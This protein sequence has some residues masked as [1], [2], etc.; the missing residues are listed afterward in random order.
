MSDS[1][2]F[3]L[4]NIRV[5]ALIVQRDSLLI[6]EEKHGHLFLTKFPGGGLQFGE[7][8][9]DALKRELIE[10]LNVEVSDTKLFHVTESFVTSFLNKNQ[11][12]VG[13]YY[14]VNLKE[15][16]TNQYLE[17]NKLELENGFVE[18]KWKSFDELHPEKFSSMIDQEVFKKLMDA[19]K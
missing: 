5:Y 9:P 10:E 15:E 3:P 14:L 17:D 2:L 16:L 13:V 18:F 12:V 6:T 7:S 1:N 4:F 11:Q 19:I 8:I